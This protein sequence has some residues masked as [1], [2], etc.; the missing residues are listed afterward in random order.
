[1][2][3]GGLLVVPAL[4][5]L[6]LAAHFFHA[7]AGLVAACCIALVA[8]LFIPRRW[9]GRTVQLVLAAGAVEWVLTA[10]TLA[11]LRLRHDEPYLRLVFILGGVAVFTAIAA[12]LFQHPALRARFAFAPRLVPAPAQES[13]D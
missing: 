7:G 3:F 1:M 2:R 4:A 13:T 8:L 11:Q 10:Y 9:A 6:L 5:L 12:A